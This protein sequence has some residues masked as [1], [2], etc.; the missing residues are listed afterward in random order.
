M[1]SR[2]ESDFLGGYVTFSVKLE[3]VSTLRPKAA[4]LRDPPLEMFLPA[5][6]TCPKAKAS[7]KTIISIR[8][9]PNMSVL[10][11]GLGGDFMR[12]TGERAYLEWRMMYVNSFGNKL[13]HVKFTL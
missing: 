3:G 6:L 7:K 4:R 11:E 2:P 9:V 5:S 13:Y 8:G 12:E 1:G 10:C